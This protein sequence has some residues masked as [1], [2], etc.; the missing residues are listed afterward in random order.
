MSRWY[1][2]RFRNNAGD[3]YDIESSGNTRKSAARTSRSKLRD[4]IGEKHKDFFVTRV[5]P[6]TPPADR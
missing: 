4:L 2:V 3:Y 5:A 1:T 6:C